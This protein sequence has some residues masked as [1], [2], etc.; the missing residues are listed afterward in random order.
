MYHGLCLEITTGTD[1]KACNE[2]LMWLM[3]SCCKKNIVGCLLTA[4]KDL[5][6]KIFGN[7]YRCA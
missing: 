4:E 3:S 2:L 5:H 6:S 7:R 1:V